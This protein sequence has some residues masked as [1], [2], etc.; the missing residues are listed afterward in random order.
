VPKY[1]EEAG[2]I[3]KPFPSVKQTFWPP[4]G[5]LLVLKIV[6]VHKRISPPLAGGD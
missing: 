1:P 4:I 5:K 6:Y 2:S 3:G